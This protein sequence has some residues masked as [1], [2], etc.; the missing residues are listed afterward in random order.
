MSSSIFGSQS[1]F[2][3]PSSGNPT[4]SNSWHTSPCPSSQQSPNTGT[5]LIRQRKRPELHRFGSKSWVVGSQTVS[6]SSSSRNTPTTNSQ[7]T[8]PCSSTQD[9]P[10]PILPFSNDCGIRWEDPRP[11]QNV[12]IPEVLNIERRGRYFMT[13]GRQRRCSTSKAGLFGSNHNHCDNFG[14]KTNM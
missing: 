9:A 11:L 4:S 13:L 12:T 6:T 10:S 5:Q 8:S 14:S 7:N 3:S 2:P 1:V